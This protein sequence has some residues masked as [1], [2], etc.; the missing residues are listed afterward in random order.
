MR[1]RD[2]S[3]MLTMSATAPMV[4][5]CVRC[6]MAPKSTAS[7]NAAHSTCEVIAPMSMFCMGKL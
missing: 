4:Q 1:M 2:Q 5:K 7:A 6:A 3:P